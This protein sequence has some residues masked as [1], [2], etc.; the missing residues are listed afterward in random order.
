M[1]QPIIHDLQQLKDPA[2]AKVLRRYFKTGK[3]EYGEG[4]VFWGLTVPQVRSIAKKYKDLPLA[5]VEKLLHSKVHEFRL[6]A[7][8]ILTYKKLTKNIVDLY[9]RNTSYINNW[10][11]VDLSSHEILGKFLLDKPHTVLFKLAR[12][13]NMW[14]RRIAIISTFAF[15]RN[16]DTSDTMKLA[17][18]LLHDTEDLLHKA[19]GWALREVGKQDRK[20]LVDYLSTRY[21]TMLR[22]TLRY[23]IE[24]FSTEKRQQ[25]LKG[26]I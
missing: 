2:K 8:I 14:E 11:L 4:D 17:D 19:V 16:N 15:L 6:T 18:L 13:A 10:D 3:G 1:A 7:V 12:S 22:T 25:Y 9:L 23:A 24:K 26:T 5:D 21:H 20:L